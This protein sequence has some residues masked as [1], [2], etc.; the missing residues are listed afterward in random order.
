[1]ALT[2]HVRAATFSEA[3]VVAGNL[4]LPVTL[5][6]ALSR[7]RFL[8]LKNWPGWRS[9]P[10]EPC[11][12]PGISSLLGCF[13]FFARNICH[14]SSLPGWVSFHSEGGA[15]TV[16]LKL[17]HAQQHLMALEDENEIS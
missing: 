12:H 9:R 5:P 8:F 2:N 10:P 13:F 7:W 16:V 6:L 17:S 14:P 3:A 1:M 4:P 11:G 15:V